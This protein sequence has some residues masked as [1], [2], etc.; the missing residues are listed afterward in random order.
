MGRVAAGQ[1]I[2][3]VENP[4][5]ISLGELPVPRTYLSFRSKARV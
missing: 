1:P 3:A 2:E 4:E 5:T